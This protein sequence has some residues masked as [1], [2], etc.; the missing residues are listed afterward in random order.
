[1]GW[2]M[3]NYAMRKAD[4]PALGADLSAGRTAT[5]YRFGNDVSARVGGT[6]T[7]GT[8]CADNGDRSAAKDF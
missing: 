8:N 6:F 4:M 1:M 5:I 7:P 2:H 3:S